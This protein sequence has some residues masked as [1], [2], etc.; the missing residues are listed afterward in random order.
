MW[1][2][3]K[4]KKNAAWSSVRFYAFSFQILQR[5]DLVSQVIPSKQNTLLPKPNK[6][7][8]SGC[9][10]FLRIQKGAIPCALTV[11]HCE[12]SYSVF[13]LIFNFYFSVK[14]HCALLKLVVSFF[15][16]FLVFKLHIFSSLSSSSSSPPPP[17]INLFL[18]IIKIFPH[19]H[20]YIF[21]S[22]CHHISK[23]SSSLLF[24][25]L[26]ELGVRLISC[27]N[28]NQFL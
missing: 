18:I 21:C 26:L 2:P 4:K 10:F 3:K 23:F 27:N 6:S 9:L 8:T 25:L 16:S 22:H 14:V 13:L 28:I 24:L 1:F 7:L 17:K 19:I 20:S 5:L 11:F 12:S 15:L